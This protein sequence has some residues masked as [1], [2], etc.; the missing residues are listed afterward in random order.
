MTGRRSLLSSLAAAGLAAQTAGTAEP[1]AGRRKIRV[2]AMGV[3][4]YSFWGIWADILS[5]KGKLGGGM[6]NMEVTHCWDVNP[7]LSAEFAAKW[8]CQA[9]SK[10]DG[11]TGKVDAIAFGG[12]YE[13]PWQ[14]LLARPY[15]EARIPTY[16]SRPFSYR[17]RDIDFTLNLAAKHGTPLMATS[18]QEHYYQASYLKERLRNVGVIKAVHGVGWSDEYPGHFHIQWF[19]LRAL[20]YDVDKISLVTDDDRKARYLQE[21]MLFSGWEGQP[22]FLASLHGVVGNH[23]LYLNVMGD[24]GSESI[25]MDRSPDPR[26]TLYFYFAPQLFDMQRTFEGQSYQPLD[27]IRKKTQTF[28]AGYY[29]HQE[30]GGSLVPVSGVP[31]DWQARPLRPDWMDAS[32]FR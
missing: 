28:L 1:S 23:Y 15:V 32:M 29:S 11:M 17:L 9:V 13:A 16:L 2:G 22:P 25:V 8:N 18:V 21:T 4:E 6:L 14:H 24:K 20:G 12:I 27:V 31:V 19:I 10:Y 5:S 7:K 3:G 26:E 30:R